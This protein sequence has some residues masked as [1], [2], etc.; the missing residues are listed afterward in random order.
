MSALD[1]QRSRATAIARELVSRAPSGSIA[2]IF[3]GGSLARGE[4]WAA[5]RDGV[6]EIYSDVDLYVVVDAPKARAAVRAAASGLGDAV[7]DGA[8]FLRP[9]DIG[10]YAR[11]DLRA[12][13]A[14]PGTVDLSAHHVVLHGDPAI[15][16]AL[17]P[18]GRTRMAGDE[19]LYL[20]ENRALE[21]DATETNPAGA[22]ARMA[23]VRS[24]KARL[25]VHIAHAIADGSF[26]PTLAARAAA[27]DTAAPG[28]LD[29]PSRLDV[30]RAYHL[31]HIL[32]EWLET[33]N[34][35]DEVERA[36]VAV[37]RAWRALAPRVLRA[38]GERLTGL[39]ARRW[40]E[41]ARVHNARELV[42]MRHAYGVPLGR[43]IV[44]APAL[45]VCSPRAALRLDALIRRF[46]GEG[47]IDDAVFDP[48]RQRLDALTRL[49][50]FSDGS[51][52]TRVRDMHRVIS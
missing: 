20:L 40:R 2:C 27:F 34:P 25:D 6:L 35:G 46:H 37:S 15:P 31:A 5:A 3:A 26:A 28:S 36:M 51:Q 33:A 17:P 14:R 1:M 47:R 50:G 49:Y 10:V 30:A 18:Y 13:P 12:Q 24:L 7:V 21:L 19:A 4:V 16:A 8:L 52:E 48:H 43:V 22:A 39:L 23:V 29:E 41:G 42:R 38:P 32:P 11:E 45:S 44:A 9:A